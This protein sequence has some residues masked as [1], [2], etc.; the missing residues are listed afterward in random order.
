MCTHN[1]PI[2]VLHYNF[3]FSQDLVKENSQG[4]KWLYKKTPAYFCIVFFNFKWCSSSIVSM[5]I[6]CLSCHAFVNCGQSS[7]QKPFLLVWQNLKWPK[8]SICKC[9]NFS[10]FASYL[11]AI[12]V[13][14]GNVYL[15]VLTKAKLN[16]D[17]RSSNGK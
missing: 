2:W 17:W 10:T 7:T 15:L 11:F 9:Q 14:S 4:I 12:L 16:I 5:E 13:P 1:L 6:L 3:W 8:I